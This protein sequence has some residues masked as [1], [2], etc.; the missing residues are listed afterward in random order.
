VVIH[1]AAPHDV[2]PLVALSYGLTP[3]E[4]EVVML[5]IQGRATKEIARVLSLSPY[6]VQDHLKSV[7]AKTGVGSR[8]E[9]VGRI[10]LDHYAPRWQT[11]ALAPPGV[12]ALS[13][14]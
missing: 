7:F 8:G 10:F 12:R 3:R 14:E 9:L 5:C 6:T 13:I 11:P 4:C 1:P 2:A